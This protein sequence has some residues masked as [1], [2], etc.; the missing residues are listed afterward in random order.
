MN[1]TSRFHRFYHQECTLEQRDAIQSK[2]LQKVAEYIKDLEFPLRHAL[3]IA[4][5]HTDKVND[6]DIELVHLIVSRARHFPLDW[7][8]VFIIVFDHCSS[9]FA[10]E[11]FRRK[12][13]DTLYNTIDYHRLAAYAVNKGDEE[14]LCALLDD[15]YC[16]IHLDNNRMFHNAVRASRKR[17]FEQ[18]LNHSRNTLDDRT[19][20]NHYDAITI[21]IKAGYV[22]LLNTRELKEHS[23][24]LNEPV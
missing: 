16:W 21:A 9:Q 15:Q 10:V 7:N 22:D 13:V 3:I 18:L 1:C 14:L 17:I 19:A 6:I 24:F 12:L 4:T 23:L 2:D 5:E 11:W 20:Y 8:D